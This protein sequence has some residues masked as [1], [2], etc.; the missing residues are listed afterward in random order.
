MEAGMGADLEVRVE[1]GGG[2]PIPARHVAI[3]KTSYLFIKS[4]YVT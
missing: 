3:P 1:D 2:K 4:K